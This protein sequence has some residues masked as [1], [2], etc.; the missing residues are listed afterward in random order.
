MK[1]GNFYAFDILDRD[2]KEHE[3][4]LLFS[5]HRGRIDKINC[6]HLGTQIGY[7]V[8]PTSSS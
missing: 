5:A 4:Q 7:L 1:R 8:Y 2:G 6:L 3:G